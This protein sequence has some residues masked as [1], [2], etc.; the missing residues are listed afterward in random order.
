M[1][2]QQISKAEKARI[3]REAIGDMRQAARLLQK[4]SSAYGED[5]THC[6]WN[7]FELLVTAGIKE[8]ELTGEIKVPA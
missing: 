3:D 7:A 6:S 1:T 2:R 8:A 4:I 5:P